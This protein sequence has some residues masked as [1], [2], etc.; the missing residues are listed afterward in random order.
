MQFP[1]I[2]PDAIEQETSNDLETLNSE[3]DYLIAAE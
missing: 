1:A 2:D 3:D